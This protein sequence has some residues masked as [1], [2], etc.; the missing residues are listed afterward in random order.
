MK[1]IFTKIEDGKILVSLSK[2]FYEKSAVFAA[3]H[4][5][6]GRFVV[7][8]EPLDERTAGIYFQ[9]KPGIEMNENDLKEAAFDFC[10]EVL[11]Q[12]IRLD[13]ETRYG[14]I[15]EIIVKQ[16]FAPISLSELTKVIG[17]RPDDNG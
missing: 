16:A 8:I 5:L 7:L 1:G 17:G 13:L 6:S 15:R 12:Q 9:P 4:K 10:N 2:E 14:H 3:A 11:D